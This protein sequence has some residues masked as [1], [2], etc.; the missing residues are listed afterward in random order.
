MGSEHYIILLLIVTRLSGLL[1]ASHAAVDNTSK[2]DEAVTAAEISNGLG[3]KM[4]SCLSGSS[5]NAHNNLLFSPVSIATSLAIIY[6]GALGNSSREIR[7]ELSS[8]LQPLS[9][10]SLCGDIKKNKSVMMTNYKPNE[11]KCKCPPGAYFKALLSTLQTYN[12]TNSTIDI[13]NGIWHHGQFHPLFKHSAK[14]YFKP[15]LMTFNPNK[16]IVAASMINQWINNM[17]RGKISNI[18]NADSIRES[19]KVLLFNV[20]YFRGLWHTSFNASNSTE[21]FITCKACHGNKVNITTEGSVEQVQYIEKMENVPYCEMPSTL[22]AIRM[23]YVNRDISMT[24][25]LPKKLCSL[26]SIEDQLINGD[27]LQRINNNCLTPRLIRIEIPKFELE[28]ELPV[29][30]I[31]SKLGLQSHVGFST[32]LKKTRNLKLSKVSHQSVLKVNEE[33]IDYK[34]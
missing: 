22:T 7:C 32:I 28:Q 3:W 31:L 21:S 14:K 17:T 24:I 19:D 6:Y 25:I 13:A 33:G 34:H 10:P 11:V 15:R 29:N 2:V 9:V 20:L 18:I 30:S 26:G 23:P 27:L 1:H 4:F 8:L 12:T 16:P 5:N